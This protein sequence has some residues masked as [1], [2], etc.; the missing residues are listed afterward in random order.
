MTFDF[1][2]DITGCSTR[3][4]LGNSASRQFGV[5]NFN[6]HP[7]TMNLLDIGNRG[8]EDPSNIHIS[9]E[10]VHI[11]HH[12]FKSYVCSVHTIS[13]EFKYTLYCFSI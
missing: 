11:H 9:I 13:V 7:S 4:L 1:Y 5:S 3:D 12:M 6:I 8:W 2:R 10:L